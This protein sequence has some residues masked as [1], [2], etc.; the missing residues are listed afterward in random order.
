MIDITDKKN[1]EKKFSQDDPIVGIVKQLDT[2]LN[3]QEDSN[4]SKIKK[5]YEYLNNPS[6]ADKK[7]KN[8]DVIK[9]DNRLATRD[10][11]KII[12]VVAATILTGILPGMLVMAICY[13]ATNKQPMDLLKSDEGKKFLDRASLIKQQPSLFSMFKSDSEQKRSDSLCENNSHKPN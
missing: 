3:A 10:Y 9:Q 8:I 5:Y 12:A 2:I 1:L 6:N 11:L 7:L 13:A 4:E